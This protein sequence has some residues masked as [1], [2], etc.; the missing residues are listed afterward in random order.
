M[1][2]TRII[3]WEMSWVEKQ[4]V[5]YPNII[6]YYVQYCNNKY[7]FSNI[8]HCYYFF[9][10][11]TTYWLLLTHDYYY[12]Y[13]YFCFNSINSPIKNEKIS[14]IH[15]FTN[16]IGYYHHLFLCLYRKKMGYILLIKV[17]NSNQLYFVYCYYILLY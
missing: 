7:K 3:K 14:Y 13:L 12:I 10:V 1:Y 2:E 11:G 9:I 8:K 17:V 16:S 4:I 15:Y 6:K 5:L